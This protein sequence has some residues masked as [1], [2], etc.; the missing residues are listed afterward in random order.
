MD[1]VLTPQRDT[2]AGDTVTR[3][4]SLSTS[5]VCRARNARDTIPLRE[6]Y[7]AGAGRVA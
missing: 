6:H 2:D 7:G 3:N 5:D 4:G 1:G